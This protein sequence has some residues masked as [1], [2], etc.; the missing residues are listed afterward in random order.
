MPNCP[1]QPDSSSCGL[2]LL[3]YLEQIFNNVEQYCTSNAYRSIEHWEN[4]ECLLRK[5]FEMANLLKDLSNDQGRFDNLVFPDIQLLLKATIS[6][7]EK[8]EDQLPGAL[9]LEAEDLAVFNEYAR[10]AIKNES[11]I[12]MCREYNLPVNV[13]QQRKEQFRAM[14]RSCREDNKK[15]S[16]NISEMEEYM[17]RNKTENVYTED[18]LFSCLNEMEREGLIMTSNSTIFFLD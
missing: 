5:R 16:F 3:H 17:K 18:D 2:Y 1:K 15:T 13:T 9:T 10:Q 11:N 8:E 7:A 6:P 4:D 14:L 12:A